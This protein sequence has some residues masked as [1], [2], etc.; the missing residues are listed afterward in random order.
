MS[1]RTRAHKHVGF[2]GGRKLKQWGLTF[3]AAA[4]RAR[5]EG[6]LFTFADTRCSR[7]TVTATTAK[8]T[9]WWSEYRQQR[10][11][12]QA[13]SSHSRTHSEQPRLATERYI[14]YAARS[15]AA[16]QVPVA[17]RLACA[18]ASSA[19]FGGARAHSAGRP[20]QLPTPR[21]KA[22]ASYDDACGCGNVAR[23]CW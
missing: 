20:A 4:R 13:H 6:T 12:T 2:Y 11:H 23:M 14:F 18:I 3:D 8:H 7:P 10:A 1:T 15:H 22:V 21:A 19:F 17:D 16:E 5:S 9:V